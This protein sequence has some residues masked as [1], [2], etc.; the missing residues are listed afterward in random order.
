M[1]PL[2]SRSG[3]DPVTCKGL[4]G[5]GELGRTQIQD[6]TVP[7]VLH[8]RVLNS[9]GLDTNRISCVRLSKG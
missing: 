7:V 1:S 3:E 2:S 8:Q 4:G 6:N 9:P 5:R